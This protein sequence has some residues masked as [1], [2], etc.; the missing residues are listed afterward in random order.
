MTNLHSW[1]EVHPEVESALRQGRPVVALESAVITHGL[2]RPCNLQTARQVEEAVRSEGAVAATIAVI[3]GRPTV[4]LSDIQLEEIATSQQVKKLSRRDLPSAIVHGQ[5]GGTTVAGTLFLAHAAGIRV[6]ATGGIGGVHPAEG[7]RLDVSADLIEL[8]RTPVAVVCAGAKTILD[9]PQTLEALEALGVPVIGYGTDE[10]PGF[11][12]QS[13]GL[14][15][16]VRVDS[17]PDAAG[18]LTV[19]WQMNG[20]GA[21]L[22]Q[23][24]AADV[25]LTREEF[26]SAMAVAGRQASEHGIRGNQRTPFLL[27]R[28]AELTG[29]K[30]IRA[31]VALLVA[32]A[33]LA[34]RLAQH[35]ASN[36]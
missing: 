28:I 33:R 32:N 36:S 18:L 5:S 23:P 29:E 34:A 22:A 19:H 9:I 12:L 31:N 11:F 30:T 35:V 4:G 8:S 15:V 6:L 2:P 3:Q 7:N 1:V 13:S 25:A 21:V 14:P 27:A 16:P 10:F 20:A 24:V 26:S 17:V